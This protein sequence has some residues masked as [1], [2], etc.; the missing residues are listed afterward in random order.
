MAI[1]L[2]GVDVSIDECRKRAEA[3]DAAAQNQLALELQSSDPF[4][5]A[6]WLKKSA[7]AGYKFAQCNLAG[8]YE[9]GI[10][11]PRDYVLA[12]MW[13]SVAINSGVTWAPDQRDDLEIKMSRDEVLEAQKLARQRY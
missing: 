1:T 10:G 12:Y 2:D 3:G 5:A 7:E 8:Y 13:Y 11:L 4:Q 9:E 6:Q